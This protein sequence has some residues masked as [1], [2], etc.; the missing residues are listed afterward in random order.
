[1]LLCPKRMPQK[2]ISKP[3]YELQKHISRRRWNLC[4]VNTN[5]HIES[6]SLIWKKK[7]QKKIVHLQHWL[8]PLVSFTSKF[9]LFYASILVLWELYIIWRHHKINISEII[10]LEADC[11]ALVPWGTVFIYFFKKVQSDLL[12]MFRSLAES[13]YM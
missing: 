11:L 3:P 10:G 8:S 9:V 7:L 6:R 5:M 13:L 4:T 12:K 1:M 2:A